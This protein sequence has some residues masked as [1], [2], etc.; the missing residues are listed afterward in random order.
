MEKQV[1]GECGGCESTFTIQYTEELVSEEY[2]D[3]CPFCGET[4]DSLSEEY[5]DDDDELD[6]EREWE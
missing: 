3:H 5:I 6:E 4:I 2:P 1:T